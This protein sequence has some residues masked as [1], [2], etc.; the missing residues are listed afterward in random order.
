MRRLARPE[1]DVIRVI[2][3]P[4]REA[5][6][7]IEVTMETA[8]LRMAMVDYGLRIL[9]LSAVISAITASFLFLAVRRILVTPIRRVVG[10]MQ[11]YAQSPEDARRI[12]EPS[13]S[14]A[15]MGE[16]GIA[17]LL[18]VVGLELSLDRI[19]D[20]GGVAQGA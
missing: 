20:V 10:A 8:P 2:G 7:L 16:F 6:L 14:V 13:A 18:F 11:T 5:G 17:L 12:I 9:A 4:V 1:N 3:D 19:R 15:L